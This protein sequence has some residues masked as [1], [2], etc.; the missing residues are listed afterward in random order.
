MAL[1]LP[2]CDAQ[3]CPGHLGKFSDCVTEALWTISLDGP[4][5]Q[6]GDAIDWHAWYGHISLPESESVTIDEG[7]PD[8]RNV[9]IPSGEWILE[10]LSSGAVYA[11]QSDDI[12]TEWDALESAYAEFLGDDSE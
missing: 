12:A 2:T 1:P 3:G 11:W 8:A 9:T 10:C 4:D 6:T 7:S 5:D